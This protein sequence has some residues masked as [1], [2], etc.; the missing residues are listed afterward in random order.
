METMIVPASPVSH[1]FD[2]AGLGKPPYKFLCVTKNWFCACPGDPGKPGGS[3]D[4]CAN[5]IAFEYH[6]ASSDGKRFKVGS[7]CIWKIY[8]ETPKG[9]PATRALNAARIKHERELRHA[10]EGTTIVEGKA[11]LA[12]PEVGAALAAIPHPHTSRAARGETLADMVAWYVAHAGVSGTLWALKTA[13][14]AVAS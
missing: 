9:D 4:Y 7:D 14:K 1:P 2:R 11:W 6:V 12:R 13:R 10:R 3:C 8:R 5:G